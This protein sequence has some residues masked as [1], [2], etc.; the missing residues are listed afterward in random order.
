MISVLVLA[1]ESLFADAIVAALSQV[2][3]LDVVRM[4][5]RELGKGGH[6]SV[7]II[8]DEEEIDG[9]SIK[10]KDLIREGVTLILIKVSLESRN[11]HVFESYQLLNPE[12]DQV[13]DLLREFS[14]KYLKNQSED[15][16]GS[17]KKMNEAFIFQTGEHIRNQP[18]IPVAHLFADM[19]AII[20]EG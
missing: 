1:N 13:L 10:L 19:Q 4:S 18:Y 16:T 15:G 11:V 20:S 9:E 6:Y 17:Q 3:D 12:M 8:V 5:Q 14:R 2:I 7:I